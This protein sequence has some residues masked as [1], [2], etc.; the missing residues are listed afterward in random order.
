MKKIVIYLLTVLVFCFCEN[1]ILETI[2]TDRI[3]ESTFWQ[4]EEDAIYAANAVYR[5]LDGLMVNY[6]GLTDILHANVQFSDEASMERGEYSSLLDIIEEEWDVHYAGIQAANNFLENVDNV[7]TSDT[8]QIETLKSEVRAIRAYLYMKLVM[9][10]G[11]VPL[12]TKTLTITEGQNV[13]RDT[14][15]KIWS[16]IEEELD[17]CINTLPLVQDD[18]GRITKGAALALKMRASLYQGDYSQAAEI[19]GDIIDLNLYS[20]FPNYEGLFDYLAE[21]CSEVIL[22]KQYLKSIYSNSAFILGPYSHHNTGSKYVPTKKIVDSYSMANGKSISETTSGYDIDNPYENRDPRLKYSIFVKGSNLYNGQIYDPTPGSGTNDEIGSTYL[23]TS[24]GYNIKKYVNEDDYDD[25]T[26][27]G[28]NII[29]L[30]YAEVL[31]T[32]AEAKIEL[33]DIDQGVYDAINAVRTRSDVNLPVIESGKTQ[34]E[35]REIVRN[36]RKIEFAFE[37]HRLFDLRR[38]RTAED[39]LPGYVEGMTYKDSEGEYVTIKIE[40]FLKVFDPGK[41]YLWPI[42]SKE[43]DLNPNLEQ[44]PGW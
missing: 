5:Y 26:N 28:I 23:A 25:Y 7:E 9:L 27:C 1:N 3:S 34:S 2:P 43:I 33:N 10:Y 8:D 18:I 16:F 24:T 29:L 17:E 38:W 40:G 20:L 19:A 39:E 11:N 32:Y 22:D 35:L 14:T 44:N 4:T 21:N 30:R 37:G 42:P 41:H 31:L 12:V 13:T 36:E 6:D 15:S